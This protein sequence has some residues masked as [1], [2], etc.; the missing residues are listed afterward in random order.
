M[1]LPR[2]AEYRASGVAWL[3]EVPGHWGVNTLRQLGPLFKGQGGS[4]EDIVP[5][6][7][8]CV[9]Y[10]DLYTTHRFHI[11]EAR[12]RISPERATAYTRIQHGDVLFAASG[13]KLEEIG[14]SAANLMTDPAWCG[15]DLILWRPHALMS[16]AFLGYATDCR[17]S[18]VQKASMGRGTTVKHIYPDELRHLVL[19]IPPLPEQQAIAAFLDRETARI[20]AL[21]AE[22]ERLIALLREK[23]QALISHAVT[24][25]LDPT[26][27]M[28]DS[29]VAWMGEVPAHWDVKAAKSL[30][31]EGTSITY[32]IVQAGPHV[33]GGIPYI[34]TSDM[35]GPILPQGGYLCTTPE[36]DAAYGRSKVTT[37]DLVIAIRASVGRGLL[38]PHHLNGANLT[39]GTARFSPGHRLYP[40]YLLW[41][42]NSDYCQSEIRQFVKGT[43]FMEITLEGLRR[44]RLLVPPLPEQHAITA[45]LDTETARIDTLTAAAERAITLL[46]ERR[47]ALISAAVTGQIDVRGLAPAA[48]A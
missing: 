36:I 18:A 11:R 47:A 45:Y 39:Q 5:D 13:E 4:K 1:S 25:G 8:P 28:K 42:F 6:G 10:G 41:A 3:G 48:G 21:V 37:N 32:G 23:R 2:Y 44:V 38:V 19:A 40:I 30:T 15:G 27:P 35:S 22:Q 34:R 31:R 12:T 20:D 16:A 26:V 29:G 24:R 33:E 7:L 17:A 46:Q 14:K 9:R 43:T